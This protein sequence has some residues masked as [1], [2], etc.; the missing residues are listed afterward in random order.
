MRDSASRS[1]ARLDTLSRLSGDRLGVAK[2]CIA[3]GI[4]D[5][6]DFDCLD[7]GAIPELQKLEAIQMSAV[8]RTS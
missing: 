3:A 5:P 2:A 1:Y 8:Q 6:G 4:R 7:V